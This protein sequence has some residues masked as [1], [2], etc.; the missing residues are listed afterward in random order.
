MA[1]PKPNRRYRRI[2]LSR[3]PF[4]AWRGTGDRIV[5]RVQ[6]LGLGG[7]FILTPE[8]PAP[9]E[10][11]HLYLE[12]P[13]GEVRARAVVRSSAQGKG[14]GVEFTSMDPAARGRLHKLLTRLLGDPFA[15]GRS[16]HEPAS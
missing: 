14:M 10:V 15:Q 6:T 4:I 12:I 9:G 16:T 8:P 1:G 13:G 5:S 7:L 11:I 2:G 3:G